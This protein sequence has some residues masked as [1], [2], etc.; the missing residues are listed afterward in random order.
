M[1]WK[2][3]H[4]RRII[5]DLEEECRGLVE[6]FGTDWRNPGATSVAESAVEPGSSQM[7]M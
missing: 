2:S 6:I 4:K 1:V 7:Q 3:E 5:T